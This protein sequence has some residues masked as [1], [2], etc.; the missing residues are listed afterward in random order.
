[1]KHMMIWWDDNKDSET[2]FSNIVTDQ[3]NLNLEVSALG[4]DIHM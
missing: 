4:Q 3:N 2:Y 1:M